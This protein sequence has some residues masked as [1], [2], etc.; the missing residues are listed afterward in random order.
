MEVAN[1]K[2]NSDQPRSQGPVST[3]RKYFLVSKIRGSTP[4]GAKL[5]D[6]QNALFKH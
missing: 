2:W 4:P 1:V 5:F 3:S 6:I